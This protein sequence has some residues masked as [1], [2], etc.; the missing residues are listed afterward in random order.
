[1]LA[2][3][4]GLGVVLAAPVVEP[5]VLL[6]E[7]L[8]SQGAL[9][10]LRGS[11]EHGERA[12]AEALA[13]GLDGDAWQLPWIQTVLKPWD[14]LAP[15]WPNWSAQGWARTAAGTADP[16]GLLGDREPGLVSQ[17]VGGRL[18][19][20]NQWMELQLAPE[21]GLD[22]LGVTAVDLVTLEAW[23]AGHWRGWSAGFG[24]RERTLGPGHHGALVIGDGAQP[25]PAGEVA[26]EGAIPFVGRVRAETSMGWLPGERQ[27]VLRPGLLHMDFRWAPVP[28]VELGASRLSL[29]GGTELDGTPRPLPA[30]A[31][32]LVP[33]DPHVESDPDGELPD[34]D[35]LAAL[36]ARLV[37]PL[38][39]WIPGPVDAVEAW[40]QYGGEDMIMRSIG[41]VPTPSL[42]GV[43]NLY[44][45]QI[46]GDR[47]WVLVERAVLMDDLF[48]WYVGHR[49]Y[50]E[51]FTRDGQS[52]GH[53]NGGDQATWWGAAG[54][55]PMPWG[56]SV[57]VEQVRRVGAIQKAETGSVFT[58]MSEEHRW[59]VGG[60]AWKVQEDGGHLGLGAEVV[61]TTGRNFVPGSD[62]W[63]ARC[64]V[65]WR[66]GLRWGRTGP[67]W[68]D[69]GVSALPQGGT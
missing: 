29:F 28:W 54:W 7:Q 65:E 12:R 55:T 61:R 50:H 67:P 69:P 42:A 13:R 37:L 23:A 34:Q 20:Q 57:W 6:Q 17:R 36:D 66:T 8:V 31:Q 46:S 32:L 49:I 41:P 47:W 26:W 15:A 59:R 51:G 56:G 21:M 68:R 4:V 25:W 30:V 44:G 19:V 53:I 33:S 38:D 24:A 10:Q 63:T 35:E 22:A 9:E 64:W 2:S 43:A 27:D 1:M 52:L 16:Q 3:L 40:I 18:Q 39:L 5:E 48:R 45:V 11:S 62:D 14:D 60:Q 58:L